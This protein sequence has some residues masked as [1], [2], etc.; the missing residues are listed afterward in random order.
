MIKLISQSVFYPIVPVTSLNCD[1]EKKTNLMTAHWFIITGLSYWWTRQD[2]TPVATC[3][4]GK[5]EYKYSH[6]S[7]H[8]Y[9][10]PMHDN[11]DTSLGQLNMGKTFFNSLQCV[12]AITVSFFGGREEVGDLYLFQRFFCSFEHEL[13]R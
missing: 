8:P 13:T 6:V 7:T 3:P 2:V 10:V 12:V 11:A 5:Y 9:R 1:V 4:N